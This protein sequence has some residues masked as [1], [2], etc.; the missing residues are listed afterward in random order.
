MKYFVM[1]AVGMGHP[2]AM[3]IDGETDDIMLFETRERANVAGMR[4]PIG[5]AGRF[6]V[7]P[8]PFKA[9]L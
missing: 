6:K 7:Y 5:A 3:T 1:L 4:N 8:W 2:V 9:A